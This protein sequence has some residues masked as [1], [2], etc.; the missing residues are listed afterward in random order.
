MKILNLNLFIVL[1]CIVVSV[2]GYGLAQQ[3]VD[4]SG[5][6]KIPPPIE[7]GVQFP[8]KI[9]EKLL[10]ES[11]SIL[12]HNGE[13][14]KFTVEVAATRAQ[15]NKGLMFREAMPVDHGMLFVFDDNKERSFW[16]KNTL[17]SLDIIFIRSDGVIHSIYEEAQPRSL[18]S[19]K[20]NGPSVAALELLGGQVAKRGINIGD[21]IVSDRFQPTSASTAQ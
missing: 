8:Q 15:Q 12:K 5:P 14:H 16:M 17:I 9:D 2:S 11:L 3:E 13:R 6:I 1:F 21:R 10:V 19:I 20:S 18:Q 4:N 7:G